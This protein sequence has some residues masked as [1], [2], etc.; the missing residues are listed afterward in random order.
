MTTAKRRRATT[1]E[2]T[3]AMSYAEAAMVKIGSKD[4]YK[5]APLS[6]RELG[7][8]LHFSSEHMRRVMLRNSPLISEAFNA[9][10]CKALHLDAEVMWSKNLRERGIHK[11]QLIDEHFKDS[12]TESDEVRLL[13]MFSGLGNAERRQ[14]MRIVEGIYEQS[15]LNS[16]VS[17]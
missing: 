17:K 15:K 16:A 9:A 3:P 1:V 6:L 12:K 13:K 14:T 11:A 7:E 4:N 10:M 2:I 8:H 5:G